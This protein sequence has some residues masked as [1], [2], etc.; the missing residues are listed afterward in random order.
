MA[1]DDVRKRGGVDVGHG[2]EPAAEAPGDQ[3]ELDGAE[4]LVERAELDELAPQRVPHARR[5]EAVVAG[6]PREHLAD[7]VAQHGLFLGQLEVQLVTP[8][9]TPGSGR[10]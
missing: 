3:R 7:G 8:S 2:G 1:R 6:A 10:R 5:D 9:A 4:L